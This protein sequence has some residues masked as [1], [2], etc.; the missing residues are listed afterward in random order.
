[1]RCTDGRYETS[2]DVLDVVIV[3][4]DAGRMRYRR[5]STKVLAPLM[6]PNC[7]S[8]HCDT[9]RLPL[10]T[11]PLPPLTSTIPESHVIIYQDLKTPFST[12]GIVD[13]DPA[14]HPERVTASQPS[15]WPRQ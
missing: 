7:T 11:T 2:M 10:F 9:P 1:M 5:V 4:D 3:V 12:A 15:Q 13:S 8:S 14:Q 6:A